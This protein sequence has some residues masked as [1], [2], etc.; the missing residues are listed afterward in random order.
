MLNLPRVL[1]SRF[2]LSKKNCENIVKNCVTHGEAASATL[3]ISDIIIFNRAKKIR[4]IKHKQ[5]LSANMLRVKRYVLQT[6][7]ASV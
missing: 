6:H 5:N 2:G 3:R 4:F 7:T 1:N